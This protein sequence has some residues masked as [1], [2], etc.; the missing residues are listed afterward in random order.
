MQQQMQRESQAATQKF[1]QALLALCLSLSHTHIRHTVQ[2]AAAANAKGV[3]SSDTEVAAG[4]ARDSAPQGT[5]LGIAGQHFQTSE[6]THTICIYICICVD[7]SIEMY[8]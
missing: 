6:Y 4:L 1:Q 8:I 7:K 3:A 5:A 2:A